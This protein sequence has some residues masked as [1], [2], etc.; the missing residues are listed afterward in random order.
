MGRAILD[1]LRAG[2][3]IFLGVWLAGVLFHIAWNGGGFLEQRREE[4]QQGHWLTAVGIAA[5]GL[6]SVL[7][8]SAVVLAAL[9]LLVVVI[10][11][12]VYESGVGA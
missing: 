4:I 11:W 5:L 6:A 8:W 1:V 3:P 2:W 7:W 10:L 12:L 9:L